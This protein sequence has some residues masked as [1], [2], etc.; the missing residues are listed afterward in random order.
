MFRNCFCPKRFFCFNNGLAEDFRT[1]SLDDLHIQND[2]CCFCYYDAVVKQL[3]EPFLDSTDDLNEIL[4]D[5]GKKKQHIKMIFANFS[6]KVNKRFKFYLF[7]KVLG[8]FFSLFKVGKPSYFVALDHLQKKVVI[9][10]RGTES[11]TDSITDL[12]IRAMPIPTT[13][14][15]LE[16]HG[17]GVCL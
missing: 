17:H 7:L 6:S 1:I 3:P 16:W 14:P 10:I 12:Q 15:S 5:N 4:F 11:L 9:T 2:N 13:D 8:N